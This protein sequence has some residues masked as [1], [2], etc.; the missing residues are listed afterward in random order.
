M[1]HLFDISQIE[2]HAEAFVSR[3]AAGPAAHGQIQNRRNE[4]RFSLREKTDLDSQRKHAWRRA[5]YNF[6]RLLGKNKVFAR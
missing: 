4:I 1:G 5:A 3:Q 2:P 6:L